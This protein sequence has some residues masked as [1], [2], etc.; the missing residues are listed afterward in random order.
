MLANEM[1]PQSKTTVFRW[2]EDCFKIARNAI[3]QQLR[4]QAKSKIHL[5]FDM[6]QSPSKKAVLAVVAHYIDENF[7]YKT[8]LIGLRRV[9][10]NHTGENMVHHLID[11]IETYRI[12]DKVGYYTL[13][14]SQ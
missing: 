9:Y 2:L 7:K 10:G 3:K 12:W 5:S 1:V 6:W 8:R 13:I 14:L 4:E 11:V